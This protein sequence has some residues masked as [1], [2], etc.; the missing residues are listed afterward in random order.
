MT[1]DRDDIDAVAQRVVE[2]LEDEAAK[3]GRLV[4]AATAARLL[5][6]S[7]ATVYAKADELGAIRV[8]KGKRARLRF[9]PARMIGLG[10]TD[11]NGSQ[12]QT[13][14]RRR[15]RRSSRSDSE[16]LPIRGRNR[17]GGPLRS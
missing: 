9:D 15:P 6:V 11:S 10:K 2:L 1:L 13:H 4:D 14:D 16:L 17:S 8:G 7:R 3:P 5:G 12:D